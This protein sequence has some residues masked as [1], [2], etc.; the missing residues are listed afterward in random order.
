MGLTLGHDIGDWMNES[1]QDLMI[2]SVNYLI[3]E[4]SP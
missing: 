3:E 1:F 4:R 2:D